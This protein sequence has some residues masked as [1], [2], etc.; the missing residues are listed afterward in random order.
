MNRH[1]AVLLMTLLLIAIMSGAIALLMAQSNQLLHLSERS[2]GDAQ[3][4]KI[5]ADLKTVLP[6]ILSKITSVSDL[7]YAL[8][9]PLSSR[10][11][12]GRFS[13]EASLHSPFGLFNINNVCDASGKPR[14]P[15]ASFLPLL[16]ERYPIAAPETFINIVFDTIDTDKAQRQ[17]GS[18]IV[19][20]F[21]DFHHGSIENMSQFEQIIARYLALTKDTQI[22]EIPWKGL[23]GFEGEKID[24]NYASPEL[25]SLIVPQMNSN[26][27]HQITDLRTEAFENKER[28]LSIAPELAPHFDG[29]FFIY[30][31]GKPYPLVTEVTFQTEGES[32][33]FHV[34]VDPMDRTFKR[35]EI[36]Q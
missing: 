33:A 8:I 4:T 30:T 28:L 11:S 7:D 9:L 15:Y 20:V 31:A 3:I 6:Q 32:N 24:I 1:G 27:L 14:E 35:L 26:T 18:E 22:L 10:S 21:S 23:I 36:L 17:A 5:A 34:H 25:V 2:R 12:D 19:S 29:W 16:F 13:L